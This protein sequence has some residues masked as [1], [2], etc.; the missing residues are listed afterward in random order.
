MNKNIHI[1]GADDHGKTTVHDAIL[2]YYAEKGA[3]IIVNLPW[4]HEMS[5]DAMRAILEK[6][7]DIDLG[8]DPGMTREGK[9]AHAM[10]CRLKYGENYGS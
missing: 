9:K 2:G 1:L 4:P 10:Y 5:E 7:G 3:K 6:G 8:C